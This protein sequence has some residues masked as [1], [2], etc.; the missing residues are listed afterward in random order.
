MIKHGCA[1]LSSVI[2][3]DETGR[4]LADYPRPSVAV[5]VALMTIREEG[6][7]GVLVH[8]RDS[9]YAAGRW[10][11]PGTFVH[12]RER[13]ADAALRA[14]RDKADVAGQRPEQ[15][16]VFDDPDRDDR[17][18]VLSI[19]HV[20]LVPA[21]RLPNRGDGPDHRRPRRPARRDRAG[22]RPRRDRGQGGR[23]GPRPLPRAPRPA[24]PA[25][26]GPLHP[27]RT[28]AGARGGAR[29]E[30]PERHLPAPD[31][32]PTPSTPT[33]SPGEPWGSRPGCSGGRVPRLELK[34]GTASRCR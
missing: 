33:R 30:P 25:P 26:R 24:G 14:L 20:D 17:G 29:R 27:A 5:D 3:R 1:N 7:L 4:A 23:L 21:D 18:R 19:A 11:L 16:G 2:W 9:G 28:A 31:A 32:A 13:L 8:R 12:E 34:R 6:R 22:V 15:L 10:S